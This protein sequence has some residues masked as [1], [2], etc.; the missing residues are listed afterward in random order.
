MRGIVLGVISRRPLVLPPDVLT[1]MMLCVTLMHIVKLHHF[2]K[3]LRISFWSFVRHLSQAGPDSRLL[4]CQIST[5][6]VCGRS[7]TLSVS[8]LD[9]CGAL[10]LTMR[11]SHWSD[12][13]N[14]GR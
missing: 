9:T 13:S 11:R 8:Q 10:T 5:V 12:V 1:L 2:I 14:T 6:R 4:A 3:S 7:Q